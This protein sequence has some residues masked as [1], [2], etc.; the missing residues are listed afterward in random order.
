MFPKH[1][2]LKQYNE[3]VLVNLSFLMYFWVIVISFST[4]QQNSGASKMIFCSCLKKKVLSA[5]YVLDNE[6]GTLYKYSVNTA[7]L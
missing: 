4:I 1:V 6:I 3:P 5:G 7:T 2:F